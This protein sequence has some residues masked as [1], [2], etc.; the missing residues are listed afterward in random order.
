MLAGVPT[1]AVAS[2]YC[3]WSI[4]RRA[5]K[6]RQRLLRGRVAFLLW[7]LA[8]EADLGV[9]APNREMFLDNPFYQPA[10]GTAPNRVQVSAGQ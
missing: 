7:T 8:A 3:L 1:L 2:V 5:L 10:S 9:T 4:Y 6:K